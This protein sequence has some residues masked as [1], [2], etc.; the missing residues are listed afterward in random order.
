MPNRRCLVVLLDAFAVNFGARAGKRAVAFPP[1]GTGPARA[2][3][4]KGGKD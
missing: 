2:P 4:A 1:R 3:A